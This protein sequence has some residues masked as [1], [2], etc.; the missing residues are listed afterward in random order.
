MQG[1]MMLRCAEGET[2][3]RSALGNSPQ[4]LACGKTWCCLQL[5]SLCARWPDSCAGLFHLS[6]RQTLGVCCNVVFLTAVF[7]HVKS[8][9]GNPVVTFS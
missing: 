4:F 3:S 6:F 8:L 2:G 5:K 9:H 1:K 7:T